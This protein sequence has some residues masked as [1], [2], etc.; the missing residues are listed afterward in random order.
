MVSQSSVA[1]YN[2]SAESLCWRIQPQ[3]LPQQLDNADLIMLL[4]VQD[5]LN[6]AKHQL[7]D[8]WEPCLCVYVCSLASELGKERESTLFSASSNLD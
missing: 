5:R 1:V 2:Y 6:A 4:H 3:H 8:S 7:S